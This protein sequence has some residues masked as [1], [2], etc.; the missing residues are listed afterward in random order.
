[1][2]LKAHAF[3]LCWAR[4]SVI[5]Q[6][7]KYRA[8]ISYA[9]ADERIAARLHRALETYKVPPGAKDRAGN[10]NQTLSPIFRDK[11]ELAAHHS[12]SDTI[13][14]ALGDS[15]TLIVLCSPDA[16]KSKW[17]DA[18]IRLFRMLHGD[19][20]ILCALIAGAPE[21]SFPPALFENEREP[22]AADLMPKTFRLGV[23]QLAASMLGVGL[24]TL[25]QRDVRR[26]LRRT[27]LMMAGSFVFALVM[28][29]MA[30]TAILARGAA[31]T[32]RSEAEKM[33][34]YMISDLK[35]DLEPLGRLNI[36]SDVGKRVTDYYDAIALRDMDDD[37][38]ARRA[39][40]LHL[41]GQVALSERDS[42]QAKAEIRA[43]YDATKEILSRNPSSVDAI[44]AHAQSEFW[45]GE[46]HKQAKEFQKAKLYWA[47]YDKLSARLLAQN[48]D[49][50]AWILEGGY[51]AQNLGYINEKTQDLDAA[52]RQYRRA[53]E[54]FS[55]ALAHPDTQS[56]AAKI[57]AAEFELANLYAG[58]SALSRRTGDSEAA[59]QFRLKQIKIYEKRYGSEPKNLR[60]NFRRLQAHSARIQELGADIDPHHVDTIFIGWRNLTAS[61]RENIEWLGEYLQFVV[62]ITDA[63]DLIPIADKLSIVRTAL[64]DLAE[65]GSH[66]D[67]HHSQRYLADFIAN[68]E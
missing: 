59:D 67:L 32:S 1:M 19:S 63:R 17:V 46:I 65:I 23:T 18:E 11:T 25:L 61:D 52:S 21:S 51:S 7:F 68:N 3:A 22:L 60:N 26:R 27:Q 50:L 57:R 47:E 35:Q 29:S 24:D 34:E 53:G 5:K 41:L 20:G 58:Q 45:V 62:G 44:F 30:T 40:A 36:L 9:H 48:P 15:R 8:F 33:A 64:A 2:G 10:R 54:Y 38:L 31:E 42:A 37:R 14:A 16:Q 28:G 39:R 49:D 56:D 4:G 13:K 6:Q 12:L 66:P 55:R 43:G